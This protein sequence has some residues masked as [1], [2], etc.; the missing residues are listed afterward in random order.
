[1]SL[2][3][4]SGSRFSVNF[5]VRLP[6]PAIVDKSGSPFLEVPGPEVPEQAW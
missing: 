6:D 5:E 1:M 2:N 4:H 3:T